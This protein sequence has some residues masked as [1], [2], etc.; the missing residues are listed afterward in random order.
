MDLQSLKKALEPL[1]RFGMQETSFE[2]EG[3]TVV[4]RPLLPK[5]EISCQQYAQNILEEAR[6]A[7]GLDDDDELSRS[8]ALS[9]FDEFRADIL[10]CAIVQINDTDLR[11]VKVIE[12]KIGKTPAIPTMSKIVTEAAR[13]PPPTTFRDSASRWNRCEN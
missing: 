2:V 6:L 7:D 13:Q 11:D 3:T 1:S 9:Y 12:T 8:A 5:E 4:L 10:A